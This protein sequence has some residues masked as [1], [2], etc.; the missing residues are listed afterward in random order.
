MQ[1]SKEQ[2]QQIIKEE[3]EAVIDEKKKSGGKKRCMLPQS[4]C[5]L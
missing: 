2:L 5:S 3:I 1:M 4:A